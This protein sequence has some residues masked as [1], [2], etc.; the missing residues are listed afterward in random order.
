MDMTE[1]KEDLKNGICQK[2]IDWIK[3]HKTYDI[4]LLIALV[5][6]P[7]IIQRIE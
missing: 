6:K 3:E 2:N 7:I 5:R 4:I 1:K